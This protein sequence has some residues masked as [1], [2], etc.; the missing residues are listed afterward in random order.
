MNVKIDLITGKN[1]QNLTSNRTT[2]ISQDNFNFLRH[3]KIINNAK[4]NFWSCTKM[5]LY[6]E[7]KENKFNEIFQIKKEKNPNEKILYMINNNQVIKNLLKKIKKE[8]LINIISKKNVSKIVSRGLLKSL[9]FNNIDKSKYNLIIDCAGNN[10]RLSRSNFESE[11]YKRSY[12]EV[13]VTTIV[14]HNKSKNDTARQIFFDNEIFALLPISNTKTSIV[15]SIK[16]QKKINEIVFR[17]KINSYINFFLDNAK[18]ISRIEC[19]NLNLLIRKKYY[20]DRVLLFGDALH[21]AHPL[22]GQGFNMIL[23]D[24]IDLEKIIKNKIN[25]GLDVG[26]SDI[27]KEFSNETKP[28]NFVY[29]MGIDFLKNSFSANNKSF[30]YFRNFVIS[31][32]NK[33][34]LAK[35]FVYNIANKGF[36]F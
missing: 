18:I 17:K 16:K 3:L 8:K 30:K 12:E 25:L 2:A 31:N 20:E 34:N 6:T 14:Q 4:I 32:L 24:L 21:L 1:N 19:R 13:A 22:A 35:D 23:R 9:K 28:R 29:L 5:K 7:S 26:S 15:W 10:S 11:V 27:L 36:R 33:N